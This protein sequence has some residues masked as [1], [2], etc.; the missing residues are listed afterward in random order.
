MISHP[1]E[2]LYISEVCH[3]EQQYSGYS[4]IINRAIEQCYR[5]IVTFGN[6]RTKSALVGSD[7]IEY[8]PHF[9]KTSAVC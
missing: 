9:C 1:A 6:H 4:A 5:T 8:R 7:A 2:L 3:R